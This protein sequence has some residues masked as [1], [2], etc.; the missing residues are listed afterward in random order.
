[1]SIMR[2]FIGKFFVAGVLFFISPMLSSQASEKVKVLT[3][4][5]PVHGLSLM[6]LEE[7]L[8]DVDILSNPN[9]SPHG[10]MLKPSDIRKMKEADLVIQIGPSL[11]SSLQKALIE[12]AG[13]KL[14]TLENV[15]GLNLRSVRQGGVWGEGHHDH[16]DH[17]GH[18][19]HNH[20][21][22]SHEH[23]EKHQSHMM[24]NDHEGHKDHESHMAM[25]QA[26]MS[27]ENHQHGDHENHIVHS[28]IHG[29][30]HND[31]HQ[32]HAVE[33]HGDANHHSQ[34]MTDPHIWLDPKNARLMLGAIVERAMTLKPDLSS[35]LKEKLEAANKTLAA[36]EQKIGQDL[37]GLSDRPYLVFH[38]AYQYFEA[39]YNLNAAGAVLLDPERKPG[40]KRIAA[41]K[42][43]L[44]EDEI[45]CIFSEP[46]FSPKLLDVIV[47]DT[48]IKKAVL[49]PLGA[50][51]KLD[52]DFYPA[53]LENMAKSMTACLSD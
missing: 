4:I 41:L 20:A 14:L 48:D 33:H 11:E 29:E 1:M 30:E 51:L 28:H 5:Y 26:N 22:I 37:A 44:K 34:K 40:A 18:D 24:N 12:H 38:D 25:H 10:R 21:D 53:L 27:D 50:G 32:D 8:F 6:A 42:D 7:D 43:H 31:H 47:E 17:E 13:G 52:Q 45:K 15:A 39:A 2:N 9:A 49:D 36:L 16:G 46:Q 19:S 23:D 35:R 3:T